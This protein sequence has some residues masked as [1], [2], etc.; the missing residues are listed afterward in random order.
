ME[1][2]YYDFDSKRSLTSL[3]VTPLVF[4]QAIN[5]GLYMNGI[6]RKLMTGEYPLDDSPIVYLK[7]P[8]S[9]N[10]LVD[11]LPI[12]AVAAFVIS[13]KLRDMLIEN[14][15]TG[16]KSF[17][18]IIRK[19]NGEEIPGY[20]GFA[21]TGRNPKTYALNNDFIP[22]VF[23]LSPDIDIFVCNSKVKNLF[24]QYG[25]TGMQF[26]DFI[27]AQYKPHYESYKEFIKLLP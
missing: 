4:E 22:D 9:R 12:L 8:C 26:V 5:N 27:T 1:N 17:D 18:I 25:I 14:N 15:V 19:R 16:W 2:N 10:K 7:E 20:C 13:T 6:N 11:V 24:K 3:C 23:K 21:V